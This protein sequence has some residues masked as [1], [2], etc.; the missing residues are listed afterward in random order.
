MA[1]SSTAHSRPPNDAICSVDNVAKSSSV[2]IIGVSSGVSADTS[3]GS[4]AASHRTPGTGVTLPFTSSKLAI[5]ARNSP[6]STSSCSA[7]GYRPSMA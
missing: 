4:G 6:A 5:S 1:A 3:G 7:L 2:V